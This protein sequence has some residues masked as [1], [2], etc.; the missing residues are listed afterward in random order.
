MPRGWWEGQIA[1]GN[2]ASPTAVVVAL[3]SFFE[4]QDMDI[5]YTGK[6]RVL[7]QED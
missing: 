4:E 1:C 7:C 5:K 2:K 6:E 3:F